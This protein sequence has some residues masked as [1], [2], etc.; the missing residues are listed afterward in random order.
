MKNFGKIIAM[1]ALTLCAL[2]AEAQSFSKMHSDAIVSGQINQGQ[3]LQAPSYQYTN[4]LL[5]RKVTV[6]S[7]AASQQKSAYSPVAPL[8]G[9]GI[10]TGGAK[11]TKGGG[12]RGA[13]SSFGGSPI[14]S[15]GGTTAGSEVA[16]VADGGLDI[17]DGDFQPGQITPLGDALIPMII[18]LLCYCLFLLVRADAKADD[19]KE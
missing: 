12:L 3:L 7:A 6:K 15:Y 10:Y 14:I 5:N 1:I 13:A 9:R 16:A 11:S 18:L 2:C 19:A 8:S 17:G 4:P